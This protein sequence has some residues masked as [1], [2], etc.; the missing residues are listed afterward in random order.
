MSASIPPQRSSPSALIAF[1]N[2][3][4]APSAQLT[5]S[6]SRRQAQLAASLALVLAVFN[7]TGGLFSLQRGSQ[8]IILAFGFPVLISILSYIITRT[9]FFSVGAFL[10][11]VGVCT[12]AYT[13]IIL[14]NQEVG[15]NILLYVPIALTVG[16]ALLSPWALLLLTGLNVGVTLLILPALGI[17]LPNNIGSPV[18]LITAFGI[19]LILLNNFRQR[20][21]AQRL[22]E[23]QQ[24]N[25]ELMNIHA[26]L[27]KRIE[28]RTQELSRRTA[29]MEASTLV[30]RSAAMV[31]SLNE[32]MENV[33]EQITDR[34]GFY[35]TGI[36]LSDAV[37]KYVVLQA[38]SSEGG[39]QLL[40][41]GFKIEIGRQSV[42]GYAA[43]QKRPRIVQDVAT[44][45]AY[46]HIPELS[47]TRAEAA[48]PLIV[49]NRVIGVIDIQA[50]EN[51]AFKFDD[52]YTLQTMAD[53]IALAIDNTNLLEES[54]TALQQLEILNAAGAAQTWKTRLQEGA[55]G[56]TYTP[57]G[58]A[59]ASENARGA[60]TKTDK[61]I[62]V[63]LKLRGK[64]IGEIS[65]KRKE[66]DPNWTEAEREMAE[67]V[68]NQVALAVENARLLEESQRRAAREQKV[69]EFSK[70]FS[71]S[72]DVD[73]LLQ[74][75]VRELHS[76]PQVSEISVLIN[77][78]KGTGKAKQ[79]P[80][81]D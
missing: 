5:D 19:V 50:E 57:L 58:V 32:L 47:S 59:P 6:F 29:Q 40:K 25:Q 56:F 80:A 15:I 7:F 10:L 38:A 43:Y 55:R 66:S 18:G 14:E 64:P 27:E 3:L 72:L 2:W 44:D 76:L 24:T 67:R 54:R 35:H 17:E 20:L 31:R 51:N 4:T 52:I 53:Q 1:G 22:E 12:S 65:L 42:V 33:V 63:P 34:L 13:N 37:D 30:A 62:S 45:P 79:P 36:F 74:N 23:I 77:P 73:A 9:K 68:A 81:M 46:I 39:K 16:S 8:G 28:E 26:N 69:S 71:R 41:R 61:I 21:E 11:V 60:D 49:R 75:A 48:L 78:E 70:R